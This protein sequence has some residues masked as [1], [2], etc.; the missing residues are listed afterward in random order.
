MGGRQ[1]PK[2]DAEIFM[3][4]HIYMLLHIKYKSLVQ[5]LQQTWTL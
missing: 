3:L 2:F 1:T 5:F 4:L